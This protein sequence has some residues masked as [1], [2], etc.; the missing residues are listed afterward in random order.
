M[1]D[2][3]FHHKQLICLAPMVRAGSLPLR[4]LCLSYGADLVWTEEFIDKKI[5]NAIRVENVLLNTTDYVV[6][7]VVVFRTDN[8]LEKKR[9]VFQI[10]S[11]DAT[12]A[13][14]AARVVENGISMLQ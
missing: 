14:Q 5:I 6:D 13:L 3:I 11:S 10:G 12:L 4:S 7:G 2:S 8:N 1:K 9:L